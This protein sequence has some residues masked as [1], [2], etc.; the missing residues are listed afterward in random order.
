MYII[1]IYM[2]TVKYECMNGLGDKILDSIGVCVL[3][4]FLRYKPRIV[5]NQN[6]PQT[7]AW[8]KNTYDLRLC[9]ST[10]FPVDNTKTPATYFVQ[11]P[12]PSVSLCPY[13]VYIFLR[14]KLPTITFEDVSNKYIDFMQKY[15]VPSFC[16]TSI[17]PD[18]I[19]N[20]YGIHLRRTDKLNTANT[21]N[22]HECSTN[23]FDDITNKL[24]YD[25]KSIMLT[26]ENPAFLIVSEDAEWKQ[27]IASHLQEYSTANSR[28][29]QLLNINYLDNNDVNTLCGFESIADMFCLAKCKMIFQGVKYSTFS[30][31]ASIIG[32]GKLQ[33]YV[34]VVSNSDWN[35]IDAWSSVLDIN[36]RGRNFDPSV[37]SKIVCTEL[38]TNIPTRIPRQ[39]N[40]KNSASSPPPL[41]P[42]KIYTLEHLQWDAIQRSTKIQGQRYCEAISPL[43][44]ADT[45]NQLKDN[46]LKVADRPISNI[47]RCKPAHKFVPSQNIKSVKI[48]PKANNTHNNK[49]LGYGNTTMFMK[50]I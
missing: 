31:V 8:G 19:E 39:I 15:I 18:G 26:E 6:V 11:S 46:P 22:G 24:L 5:F 7:F 37:H 41:T 42:L 36:G 44:G 34:H 16:I 48:I 33:N 35:L 43:K 40:I 4:Y 2:V 20:A 25:I 45:I 29:I 23:E 38:I 50:F 49:K 12:N 21:N 28:S 9:T 10:S 27:H 13:K 1:T 32:T 47:H 14:G 3:C 17:F 30:M